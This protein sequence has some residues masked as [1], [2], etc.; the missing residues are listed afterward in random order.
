MLSAPACRR[1][2]GQPTPST[3]ALDRP[4]REFHIPA[5]AAIALGADRILKIDAL[6]SLRQGR[7]QRVSQ[8]SRFHLGS[9]AKAI[10][11]T[12]VA[13]LVEQ[14][15]LAWQSSPLDV[16]PEWKKSIHPAYSNISL[17]DLFRHRAGLPPFQPI[18]A[19]EFRGFPHS[20]SRVDC[21]HWILQMPPVTRPGKRALY[22]N[23]GPCIATVM[24]ER[25]TG[26]RWEDL[27]C[28][29]VFAPLATAAG[30]GWPAATDPKQPWG[31]R[32]S[33]F[34]PRPVDPNTAYPLPD[35][36]RPAGDVCMDLSAYGRFLQVHLAG[37]QGRDS[38]LR[39]DTVRHLHTPVDGCGL[40]WGVG[41]ID[42]LMCSDHVG[43]AGS[44][45]AVVTIWHT[46]GVAVAVAA[47]LDSDQA[48][49]ACRAASRAIYR[50]FA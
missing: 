22:S 14:G 9:L 11:A 19:A 10:T 16:F 21:A 34:G 36:F 1:D 4:R 12:M 7:P 3:S 43:G 25:V 33:W 44:F 2:S 6:G 27:L 23:A 41:L 20:L 42:G 47:N 49:Q 32:P 24:A 28:E 29:R 15:K 40:G 31:H 18:G 5:M 26:R 50:L 13:T 37:L 8:S 17:D 46:K 45:L 38:L 39:S 30:F 35:F 48:T